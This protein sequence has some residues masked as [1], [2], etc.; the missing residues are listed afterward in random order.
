MRTGSIP[1]RECL[2]IA[3]FT[4]SCQLTDIRDVIQ[5]GG[6]PRRLSTLLVTF[7]RYLKRTGFQ[8]IAQA[9]GRRRAPSVT[10]RAGLDADQSI[11]PGD[12]VQVRSR[13]EIRGSLD[14]YGKTGGC[15]F[16]R[17]MY[18]LCGRQYRVLKKVS[19]FFDESR[20]RIC[21]CRNIWILEGALCSG[22]QRLYAVR[23]DRN[24]FFF[25]HTAWLKRIS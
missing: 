14:R 4:V 23:C 21:H 18:G 2:R 19:A 10:G 11:R 8:L 17:E 7:L 3:G 24:C 12:W 16:T 6:L 15:A 20:Q 25:W 1:S 9:A 22:Q 5:P 13:A